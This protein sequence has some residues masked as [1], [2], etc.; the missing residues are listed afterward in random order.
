MMSTA[1]FEQKMQALLH[2]KPFQPFLIELDDG[3]QWVVG[4]KEALMYLGGDT[5]VYFRPDGSF[6]FVD[7]Q[8]VRRVVELKPVTS[9]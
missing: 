8:A 2:R 3:E 9:S 6:D 1:D 5:G 7:C 4:Q